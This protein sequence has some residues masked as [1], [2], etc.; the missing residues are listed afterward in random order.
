MLRKELAS[1]CI[2]VTPMKGTTDS[3][4]KNRNDLEEPKEQNIS[5]NSSQHPTDAGSCCL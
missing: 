1:S 4:N 3:P 2:H 5:G